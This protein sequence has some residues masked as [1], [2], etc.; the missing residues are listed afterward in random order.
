MSLRMSLCTFWYTYG[1]PLTQSHLCAEGEAPC[2]EH[3]SSL[4]KTGPL[5]SHA[6]AGRQ[7]RYT[8]LLNRAMQDNSRGG[9]GTVRCT[10]SVVDAALVRA[11]AYHAGHLTLLSLDIARRR[12]NGVP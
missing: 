3:D 1:T 4:G 10:L 12:F 5:G 6:V 7:Q 9:Q 11:A 2:Q 8:Q